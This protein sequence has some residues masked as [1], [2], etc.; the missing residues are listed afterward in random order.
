M[1]G[2]RSIIGLMFVR[3]GFVVAASVAA[4]ATRQINC[5]RPRDVK[6]SGTICII[7]SYMLAKFFLY[8]SSA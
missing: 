2:E 3:L 7:L 6:P 5:S 1:K 4:Y 8:L